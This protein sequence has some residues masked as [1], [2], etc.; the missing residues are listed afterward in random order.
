MFFNVTENMHNVIVFNIKYYVYNIN[1][2]PNININICINVY[3]LQ[4]NFR[5]NCVNKSVE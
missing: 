2:K 5:Y 4:Q 1:N 3:L